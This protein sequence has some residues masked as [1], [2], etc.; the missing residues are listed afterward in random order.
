LSHPGRLDRLLADGVI[1]GIVPDDVE[2]GLPYR[3]KRFLEDLQDLA[4]VKH[5]TSVGHCNSFAYPL[6]W[7]HPG[8]L[9]LADG[10]VGEAVPD[11]A[12]ELGLRY[13]HGRFLEDLQDLAVVKHRTSVGHCDSFVCMP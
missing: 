6:D 3:H 4:V 1:G 9:D 2:L 13:R 5:R 11:D 8:R 12:A 10:L 7:S